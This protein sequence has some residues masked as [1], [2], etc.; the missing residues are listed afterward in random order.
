MALIPAIRAQVHSNDNIVVVGGGLGVST[1]AAAEATGRT[2][3]VNTYEASRNQFNITKSTVE[4]NKLEEYVT[5]HHA[6]VGSYQSEYT[7][8]SAGNAEIIQPSSLPNDDVLVLDCEGAELE[9]LADL[10][11]N[12]R[13]IIVETHGFLDAPE[14]EIENLLSENG[15]D[16]I[17]RRVESESAGIVVLTAIKDH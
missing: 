5:V 7:H 2:G 10:N 13:T 14:S 8:G 11:Q 1:V 17:E 6:I 15:Y 9:I 16:V 4:L 3:T 12:Y